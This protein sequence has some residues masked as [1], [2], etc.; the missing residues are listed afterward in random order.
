MSVHNSLNRGAY[1]R[2]LLAYGVSTAA[3]PAAE[4]KYC[5]HENVPIRTLGSSKGDHNDIEKAER[6][7]RD[8]GRSP[9]AYRRL[10]WRCAQKS[11][12]HERIWNAVHQLARFI[13]DSYCPS[14][15]SPLDVQ[16]EDGVKLSGMPG[17]KANR[18]VRDV[19]VYPGIL[20]WQI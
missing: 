19:A 4:R 20:G 10:V 12:E 2:I 1:D 15:R 14:L 11:L 9:D 5:L 3:G 13:E 6:L 8:E 16:I 7:L 18:I 17:V